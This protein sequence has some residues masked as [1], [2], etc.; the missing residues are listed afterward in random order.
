MGYQ[1]L[2][3]YNYLDY[4]AGRR[5]RIEKLLSDF[6]E[7][8][9]FLESFLSK[10]YRGVVFKGSY[11]GRT[12]AIKVLRSDVEEK[13]PIEKECKVLEFL[14]K[15]L[16]TENPAPCPFICKKEFLVMEFI[17]GATFSRAI[18]EYNPKE[19]IKKALKSC[20]LLDKVGVEH[21]EIKGEKHLIFDGKRVRIID[22]ESTKFKELPRNLLQ[23]VGYHLIRN[24]KLLEK[25]KISKEKLKKTIEIYKQDREK[26]FHTL[27]NLFA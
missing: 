4:P 25:L 18:L 2:R 10:G 16:K 21:S 13:N 3:F 9:I 26:G 6:K 11:K 15:T 22:F 17:E 8:G 14:E 12:V 24:E 27:T 19:V 5:E 20:Y 1:T 23:F 7:K